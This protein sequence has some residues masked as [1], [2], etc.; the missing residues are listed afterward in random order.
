MGR[1]P[2]TSATRE[3]IE[4]AQKGDAEAFGELV[5]GYQHRLECLVHI[6][7]GKKLRR[8]T[9][10]ED[11][12]QDTYLRAFKSLDGFRWTRPGCFFSWLS[13]VCEHAIE[14]RARYAN[15]KKRTPPGGNKVPDPDQVAHDASRKYPFPA[16]GQ[17]DAAKR[18]RREERFQRLEKALNQLSEDHR[19]VIILAQIRGLRIKDIAEQMGRSSD[20]VSM[21][22]LR[23]LRQLK[24]HFGST[25][26]LNLPPRS[27][28]KPPG[29]GND[30]GDPAERPPSS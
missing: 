22:L 12:L 11:I 4:K 2:D 20:A 3:L 9:G 19:E 17:P 25:D 27:L 13:E 5:M 14:D 23:A 30:D 18:L 6:R 10:V 26:S 21:L 28:D 16:T 15:A 1:T 7:L 29:E 8:T 24:G